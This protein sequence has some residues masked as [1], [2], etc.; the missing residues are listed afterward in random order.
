MFAGIIFFLLLNL[1]YNQ[2]D[3]F[4]EKNDIQADVIKLKSMSQNLCFLL[5]ESPGY[6]NDWQ[7]SSPT[8]FNIFGLKNESSNDLSNSKL[9]KLS[10]SNYINISKELNL[11]ETYFNLK[12]INLSD[13]SVIKQFGV[14]ANNFS[15]SEKSVCFAS[16]NS[17]MS[18]LIVE[19][20]K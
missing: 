7:T 16:I 11:T 1:V 10:N 12:I 20:W 5:S 19:V 2:Y 9:S 17:S 18:K 13:S 4:L 15:L 14:E 6:P 3:D 8:Q